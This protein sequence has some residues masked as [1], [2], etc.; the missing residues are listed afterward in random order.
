MAAPATAPSRVRAH[1]RIPVL[2]AGYALVASSMA[3]SAL[4]VVYWFVAARRYDTESVGI[5]SA[6]VAATTLLAGLANLGLKNGLLRF[7]PQAGRDTGRLIR[8]SYALSAVCACVAGVVFLAG[9][10]VWAPDLAFLRQGIVP[11]VVF[12]ATLAAWAVFVL[13]D[14]VLVGLGQAPWVPVE[15]IVF[16]VAKI[17]MLLGLV[18]LSPRWGVFLSWGVPTVALIVV[19]N[20]GIARRML[21]RHVTAAA[22]RE[23]PAFSQVL[24]FSVTDQAATILWMAT[25]DGL[26][27][28]VLRREG[29]SA[30]AYYYL[31]AQIAYGLYFLSGC[32]G[33]AL[34]AE[35]ARDPGRLAELN[36]RVTRQAFWLVVPTTAVVVIGAPWV[37]GIFGAAYRDNATDLLRLLSLSALP[38]TVTSIALSR[39][40]VQQRMTTVVAGHGA[41][42]V[43]CVGIAAVM[44]PRYGLVGVGVGVLL[45]QTIVCGVVLASGFRHADRQLPFIAVIACLAGTRSRVRRLIAVRRLPAQM[46]RA[47]LPE[48]WDH[49]NWV[50]MASRILA[51]VQSFRFSERPCVENTHSMSIRLG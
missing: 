3:T 51:E 16:S 20:W 33:A 19:V 7:V 17:L 4:G 45:G 41:I 26:P 1:L 27:L 47:P 14:S 37:L 42:F 9:V 30:A 44:L 28:L 34:V 13:Q 10:R 35:G 2:R 32:I 50:S 11:C 6:L 46:A 39:A 5:G 24:R 23:P 49:W 18:Y 31:A 12:V 21:P 15:N 38:Y 25:L 40:R 22:D 36:R 8:R 29:A 48:G 43:L